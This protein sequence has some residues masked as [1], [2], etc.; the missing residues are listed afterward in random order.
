MDAN[1]L[2][3]GQLQAMNAR[4]DAIQAEG[5]E[6][7]R[8]MWK[9]VNDQ[10]KMLVAI[11]HRLG[12]VEKSVAGAQPTLNEVINLKARANGAG[13]LGKKLLVIG[14]AL[15]TAAG[16]IYSARDAIWQWF[17]GR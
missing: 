12:A 16:W 3:L 10:G 2:I 4:L 9:E 13:W 5:S 14:A 7:G 8:L 6:R 15:L 17:A 11:S 1:A